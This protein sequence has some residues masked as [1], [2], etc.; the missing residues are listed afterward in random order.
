M[1]LKNAV[2]TAAY[3]ASMCKE[4]RELAAASNFKTTDYALGIAMAAACDEGG[5]SLADAVRSDQ[6]R[7]VAG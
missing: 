3:I 6:P 7:R 1:T 2:D 4:L 5:I